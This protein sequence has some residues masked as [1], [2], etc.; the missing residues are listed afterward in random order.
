MGKL[1]TIVLDSSFVVL[2]KPLISP[3]L[4]YMQNR[5]VG[6]RKSFKISFPFKIL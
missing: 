3:V 4:L 5:E 6:G 2:E 1:K